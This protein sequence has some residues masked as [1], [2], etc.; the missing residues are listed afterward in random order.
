MLRI[1]APR[2]RRVWVPVTS[3][4]AREEAHSRALPSVVLRRTACR[5]RGRLGKRAARDRLD[6][7]LNS[8]EIALALGAAL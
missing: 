5:P 4:R 6:R 1:G 7:Y 2:R 8:A 3:S